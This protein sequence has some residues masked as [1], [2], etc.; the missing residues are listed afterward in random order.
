MDLSTKH[1][2]ARAAVCR[3]PALNASLTLLNKG[4]VNAR[5]D[6]YAAPRPSPGATPS[7]SVVV[8]M[9][10]ADVAGEVDEDLFQIQLAVPDEGQIT[11]ANEATG[12]EV[13]W[14]R[15][16]DGAGAWWGDASVSAEAGTGE[17]KLTNTTLY[18]GAFCR[19]ISA[20]F[21]G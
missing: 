20:I 5:I 1:S 7:G 12:T 11:G 2:N 19:L 16:V 10:L 21:Q 6:L 9:P 3:V 13:T 17:I 15:I 4:T 18:N 14:A 8:S